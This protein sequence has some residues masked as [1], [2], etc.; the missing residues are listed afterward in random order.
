MIKNA[1]TY[2]TDEMNA[3]FKLRLQ[4][5][6]DK[7]KVILSTIV[8]QN[9][10]PS[11][12]DKNVILCSL[13]NIQEEK[14]IANQRALIEQSNGRFTKTNPPVSLNLFVMFSAYFAGK[15]NPEALKFISMVVSF[16]QSK[17]SFDQMNSPGMDD[18]IFKLSFEIYNTSFMEQSNIWGS[19]GAKYMPSVLYKVRMI[20]I[21]EDAIQGEIGTITTIDQNLE[22]KFTTSP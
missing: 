3:Y 5:N 7:D 1:L 10:S 9:G 21:K 12:E 22:T 19:L 2:I 16:F 20:S 17:G 6:D 13:V 11:I 18:R 15:L 4:S 8:D 14:V